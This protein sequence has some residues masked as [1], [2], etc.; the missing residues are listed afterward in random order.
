MKVILDLDTYFHA[1]RVGSSIHGN[2][3]KPNDIDIAICFK[4]PL[5]TKQICKCLRIGK[6]NLIL[7]HGER[8]AD[9]IGGFDMNILK[10]YKSLL[11]NKLYLTDAAK[12]D[13]QNLTITQVPRY[14]LIFDA[15]DKSRPFDRAIKYASKV[16]KGYTFKPLDSLN[17]PNVM[18]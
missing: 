13:L 7:I 2:L 4:L 11:T 18:G 5:V 3:L 14:S 17:I 12:I 15:Y 6:I 9:Y 10:G 16:P 8:L 1:A